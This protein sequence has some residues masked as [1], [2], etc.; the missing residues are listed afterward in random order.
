[1]LTASWLMLEI[2]EFRC[3]E[4]R[5][6]ESE[7]AGSHQ[8]LNTFGLN[9]QYSATEPQQPQSVVWLSCIQRIVRVTGC[10]A[11]VAQWQR[12]GGSSQKCPGSRYTRRLPAF[13]LLYFCL[14]STKFLQKFKHMKLQIQ[15]SNFSTELH[16]QNL[17]PLL[18]T[19]AQLYGILTFSCTIAVYLIIRLLET[20]THSFSL[21]CVIP[22]DFGCCSLH[23]LTSAF[24]PQ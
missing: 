18:T 10:P 11:V 3:Y 19:H 17:L 5:I 24:Q 13:S 7:K 15:L 12:T 16:V 20:Y 9:R 4:V 8:E 21:F 2:K 22:P 14:I 23:I 1:M 6:E